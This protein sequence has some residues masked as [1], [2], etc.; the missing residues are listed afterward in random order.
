MEDDLH[1]ISLSEGRRRGN[2]DGQG[3]LDGLR[4]DDARKQAA[5]IDVARIRIGGFPAES[6]PDRSTSAAEFKGETPTS[7][8]CVVPAD[9]VN[10]KSRPIPRAI[11]LLH[12]S[13]FSFLRTTSPVMG[14]FSRPFPPELRKETG[15][16]AAN[17][18]E[19]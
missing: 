6:P 10:H 18:E 8:F 1:S 14:R 3:L 13:R 5:K 15:N 2:R 4:P 19:S 17:D 7:R 16:L 11:I 9:T 12:I